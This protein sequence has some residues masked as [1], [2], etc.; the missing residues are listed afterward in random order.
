[1]CAVNFNIC[2]VIFSIC[3]VIFLVSK[4][5]KLINTFTGVQVAEQ[6]RSQAETEA[7]KKQDV[8]EGTA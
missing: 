2:V 1:M 3:M 5:I 7:E 4:V 6:I 8:R